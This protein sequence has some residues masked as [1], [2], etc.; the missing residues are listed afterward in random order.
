MGWEFSLY[1]LILLFCSLN[2][3]F[4][5]VLMNTIW[6]IRLFISSVL[7]LWCHLSQMVGFDLQQEV[8]PYHLADTVIGSLY[9]W[10]LQTFSPF[11]MEIFFEWWWIPLM[12]NFQVA[13]F[14]LFRGCLLVSVIYS[15]FWETWFRI[16]LFPCSWI[17]LVFIF[18]HDGLQSL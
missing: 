16:E 15:D 13:F 7:F 5:P 2:K 10:S 4:L 18:V 17:W 12:L 14:P 1:H 9:T 6:V 11:I 8:I 3:N